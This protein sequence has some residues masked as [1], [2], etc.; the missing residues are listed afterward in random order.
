MNP[1]V[2]KADV[3]RWLK[4]GGYAPC[5]DTLVEGWWE[6]SREAWWVLVPNEITDTWI[7]R[8]ARSCGKTDDELRSE[9]L[10]ARE[11]TEKIV[12]RPPTQKAQKS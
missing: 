8:E 12:R 1:D 6:H 5:P 10:R 7:G 11:D 4:K 2:T 3:E 9:I